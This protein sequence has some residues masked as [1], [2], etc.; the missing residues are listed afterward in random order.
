MKCTGKGKLS[1]RLN[2]GALLLIEV[3]IVQKASRQFQKFFERTSMTVQRRKRDALDR[4]ISSNGWYPAEEA[5]P[6]NLARNRTLI[7]LQYEPVAGH[8]TQVIRVTERRAHAEL[9]RGKF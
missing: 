8:Q 1:I 5:V 2:R 3:V 4:A 9:I 7:E 6:C